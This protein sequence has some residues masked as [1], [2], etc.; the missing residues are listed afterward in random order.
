MTKAKP[1]PGEM[2]VLSTKDQKFRWQWTYN[3]TPH[4][5]PVH[6]E[7]VAEARTEA[8]KFARGKLRG[9]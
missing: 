5:S 8:R 1:I 6:Y 2:K 9:R 7:T 4:L 3:G